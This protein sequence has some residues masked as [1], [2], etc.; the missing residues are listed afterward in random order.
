MSE[1]LIIQ[2]GNPLQGKVKIPGAKNS[3]LPLLAST[4]L[5]DKPVKLTNVPELKDVQTML[6]M[7]RKLGKDITTNSNSL[8]ITGPVTSNKA[9][10][11]L[12][13]KMRASFLV[14]APLVGRTGEAIVPL[15]GGCNI[16]T[17]PVDLHLEGLKKLGV[18][19]KHEDGRIFAKTD[20]IIGNDVF[21]NYPSVGATEQLIMAAVV[22]RGTTTIYNGAQEPEIRDL[23][24]FLTSLGADINM[25]GSIIK[26][27]G[28]NELGKTTYG[29]LPDRIAAGT[30]MIAGTATN[31]NV[32]VTDVDTSSLKPLSLKLK[33]AGITVKEVDNTIK[34]KRDQRPDNLEIITLPFPGF[35][36]DLQAPIT[37]LLT[38]AKGKSVVKETVFDS[39]F[40]HVPELSKMGADISVT[41]SSTV[42]IN[43]KKTLRGTEVEAT[44]I[45]AGAALVIGGLAAKG[46]TVV[47]GLGHL[48]RGYSK[49]VENLRTLGADV[50]RV[51]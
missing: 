34:V 15:P 21:L 42:F 27:T 17:R 3:A 12:V 41:N 43:G 32:E 6:S 2:G 40:G 35:P 39:R 19:I 37:A 31:G 24:S 5:T 45:R 4:L 26:V 25:N 36:T 13:R 49:L 23:V 28:V 51:K 46:E 48:D 16:G 38:L 50:E 29:V 30:Y 14:L 1:K 22:A 20:G 7:V 18:K 8:Q 10:V 33:K 44:D 11:D 9:P 47:S